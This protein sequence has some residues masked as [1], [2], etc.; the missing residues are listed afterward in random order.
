LHI[1]HCH[2]GAANMVITSKLLKVENYQH[3]AAHALHLLLTYGSVNQLEEVQKI[4]PK[5]CVIVT[6]LHFK[7]HTME[8]ERAASEDK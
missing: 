1:T 5:C 3:C 7:T 2:D 6:A 8:D 4:T